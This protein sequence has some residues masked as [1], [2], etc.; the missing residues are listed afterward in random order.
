LVYGPE[1][2]DEVGAYY[3]EVT[4]LNVWSD[5]L[6]DN[7]AMGDNCHTLGKDF[8]G[9]AGADRMSYD[10]YPDE[11]YRS[12]FYTSLADIVT[13]ST[14]SSGEWSV[15][16]NHF[17]PKMLCHYVHSPLTSRYEFD[18]NVGYDTL[19]TKK[20]ARQIYDNSTSIK[21]SGISITA[22]PNP[23]NSE[24][25]IS[26]ASSQSA[27]ISIYN[28]QGQIVAKFTD[29]PS[30]KWRPK[31]LPTGIYLIRAETENGGIAETKIIYLK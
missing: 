14:Y 7:V 9:C 21:P 11:D 27:T 2:I 16:S 24:L 6:N 23:F 28:L 4:F 12:N 26:L 8:V 20:V 22:F 30:V 31:N 3:N 13:D 15:M 5:A 17:V 1:D 18:D 10:W 29:S 25:Q 19:I